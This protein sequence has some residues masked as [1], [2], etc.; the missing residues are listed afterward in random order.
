ML[1]KKVVLFLLFLIMTTAVFGGAIDKIYEKIRSGSYEDMYYVPESIEKEYLNYISTHKLDVDHPVEEWHFRLQ[2]KEYE[3]RRLTPSSAK[4]ILAVY[5]NG[6]PILDEKK[7]GWIVNLWMIKRF[8]YVPKANED[9]QMIVKLLNKMKNLG[10]IYT[11]VDAAHMA[12]KYTAKI[13]VTLKKPDSKKVDV[14]SDL[15]KAALDSYYKAVRFIYT[16]SHCYRNI[17]ERSIRVIT[18]NC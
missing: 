8:F 18:C 16:N 11:A 13:M 12:T 7:A 3:I 9:L 14:I 5:E 17:N 6:E 1:P 4:A 10:A 2:G 15:I